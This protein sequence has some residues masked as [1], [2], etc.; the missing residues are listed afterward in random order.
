MEKV[1]HPSHYS[2]GS[3]EC[4]DA[5]VAAAG[6]EAVVDFCKLNAFKYIWRAGCKEGSP[7]LEDLKKADWY[8]NKAISLVEELEEK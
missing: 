3:I 1:N 6:K 2:H 8:I 5:M 4:I 7:Y